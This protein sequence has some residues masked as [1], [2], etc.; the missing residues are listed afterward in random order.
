MKIMKNSI[1]SRGCYID[2]T[3][4]FVNLIIRNSAAGI[5]ARHPGCT[6]KS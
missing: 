6:P 4:F 5:I 2:I 3:F 1:V